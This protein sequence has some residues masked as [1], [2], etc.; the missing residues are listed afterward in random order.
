MMGRS[1]T[2]LGLAV[3]W[4]VVQDHE[5]YIDFQSTGSGTTFEL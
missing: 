1:G 5:G 3:V 4:N 2:G